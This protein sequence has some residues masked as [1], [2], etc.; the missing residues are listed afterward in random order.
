MKKAT[1][2]RGITYIGLSVG[3]ASVSALSPLTASAQAGV[4]NIRICHSTS[5]TKTPYV[6]PSVSPQGV[7]NGHLGHENDIVAPFE[8]NGVTYSKNWDLRGEITLSN[9]C[10][11]EPP[12]VD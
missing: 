10:M 7:I 4:E 6:E 1:I 8:Y 3:I 9:G 11:Y 12:V 5:S 2:S